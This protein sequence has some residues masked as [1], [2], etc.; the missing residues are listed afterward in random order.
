[1]SRSE[2]RARMAKSIENSG[3]EISKT[4]G[5]YKDLRLIVCS[6][7][8]QADLVIISKMRLSA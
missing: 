2:N 7:K 8:A 6:S 4:G 1:M 5:A 3:I